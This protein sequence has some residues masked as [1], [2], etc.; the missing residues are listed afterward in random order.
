MKNWLKKNALALCTASLAS[1]YFIP[2]G[3][4]SCFLFGEPE[5]P[6]ED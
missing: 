2:F 4:V 1:F 6:M 3:S 5:L